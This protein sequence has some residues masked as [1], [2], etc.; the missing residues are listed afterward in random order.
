M[1]N[2]SASS[3]I[4]KKDLDF[5]RSKNHTF[6]TINNFDHQIKIN[7]LEFQP[8]KSNPKH[9]FKICTAKLWSDVPNHCTHPFF[10]LS[11]Y[12]LKFMSVNP[13]IWCENLSQFNWNGSKQGQN[14][15]H[16]ACVRKITMLSKSCVWNNSQVD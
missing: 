4:F 12:W 16:Y 3:T 11:I 6:D 9:K 1:K 8:C 5:W 13:H 10:T 7:R 15:T 14:P 2:L